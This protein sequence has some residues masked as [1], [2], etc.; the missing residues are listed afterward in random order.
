MGGDAMTFLQLQAAYESERLELM[1]RIDKG[2]KRI[3]NKKE[4]TF[5][6]VQALYRYQWYM[7]KMEDEVTQ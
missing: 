3:A 5:S 2:F 6:E 4:F 1:R 7:A